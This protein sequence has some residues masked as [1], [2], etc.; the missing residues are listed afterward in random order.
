MKTLTTPIG[1]FWVDDFATTD[2]RIGI[3]DITTVENLGP[4]STYAWSLDQEEALLA[5]AGE[6]GATLEL[7]VPGGWRLRPGESLPKFL[8][9]L[10]RRA[11]AL[12]R[13]NR[14]TPTRG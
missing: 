13:T 2:T 7:L 10:T 9:A 11:A 4:N 14:M 8:E 5:S 3:A 6:V 12:P 1:P